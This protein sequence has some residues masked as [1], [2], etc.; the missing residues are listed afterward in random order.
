M[1][2]QCTRK[3]NHL[4]AAITAA[5]AF[6]PAVIIATK[7]PIFPA[8]VGTDQFRIT[9]FPSLPGKPASY[10]FHSRLVHVKGQ[11]LCECY[12]Y[13]RNQQNNGWQL[14]RH[15]TEVILPETYRL[16][17]GIALYF[18]RDCSTSFVVATTLP[19]GIN[20]NPNSEAES[21]SWW[22]SSPTDN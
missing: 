16:V 14:I 9:P 2:I 10:G 13:K 5:M 1:F 17:M 15:S 11:R 6:F 4:L 21:E 8:V 19:K 20:S 12:R 7:L 3:I 18:G 22:S